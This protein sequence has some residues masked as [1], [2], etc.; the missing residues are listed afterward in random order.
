MNSISNSS[1]AVNQYSQTI[2]PA[3]ISLEK[4]VKQETLQPSE[5]NL[6]MMQTNINQFVPQQIQQVQQASY[7]SSG[8]ENTK[9]HKSMPSTH[10]KINQSNIYG[11]SMYSNYNDQNI[12]SAN[13]CVN[14]RISSK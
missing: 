4:A 13:I 12:Q 3:Q 6:Y 14:D 5:Q 2:S 9:S 10:L 7:T 1:Q 8:T 11:K